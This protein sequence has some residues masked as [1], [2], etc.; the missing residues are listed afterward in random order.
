M[1]QFI[2]QPLSYNYNTGEI[3]FIV[4]HREF[5]DTKNGYPY[6]YGTQ[7]TITGTKDEFIKLCSDW[8][9]S[10]EKRIIEIHKKR[11]AR[12]AYTKRNTTDHCN[13]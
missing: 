12:K 13:L 2:E 3:V 1:R 9:N 6:Q 4:W 7:K 5:Y 8:E 10:I 11:A